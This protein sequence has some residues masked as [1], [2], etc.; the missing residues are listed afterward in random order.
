M[1]QSNLLE[2]AKGG[3][4]QA[5][6][7][8]MNLVLEPKGVTAKATLRENCLHIFFTSEHLLSK[9]TIASFVQSGLKAL[10]TQSFEKVR[11]YAQKVGQATPIWV[12]EWGVREGAL[13][14]ES[15][16][17]T[18]AARPQPIAPS[19]S[20]S[21]NLSLSALETQALE[22]QVPI[23]ATSVVSSP[24]E[25]QSCST[26][27]P[28]KHSNSWAQRRRQA[29]SLLSL[30]QGFSLSNRGRIVLVVGGGAFLIGGGL[31]IVLNSHANSRTTLQTSSGIPAIAKTG[32]QLSL[33][34][35]LQPA[36]AT[37]AEA[38]RYLAQMNK[39][40][41]AFYEANQRF[42]STLEELERSASI[43]S[44]SS[45]YVYR[46]V[47]R[48]QTQSVLTAT[49]KVKEL[50]SYAGT[51][52]LAQKPVGSTTV[53]GIICKTNRASTFPPVL[54]QPAAEPVQCPVDS[55]QILD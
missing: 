49:P 5:I 39:A 29:S 34:P 9:A 4:P 44:H 32:N 37:E 45:H 23:Q 20:T 28:A 36:N 13:Q 46:L 30:I 12:E 33:Q 47:I 2:L 27:K 1:T 41:Q 10:G 26:R 53:V 24:K 22:T 17:P 31:A 40:Q 52:L 35:S 51:V 43:I 54:P 11:L 42:A 55:I 25:L 21:L 19:P 3:N 15:A 18:I 48:D 50:R 6:A 16:K 7:T 38:E 8:L 14:D